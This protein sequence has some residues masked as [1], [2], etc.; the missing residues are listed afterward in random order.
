MS[1]V[2]FVESRD[3]ANTTKNYRW[4][5]EKFFSVV[6][7][8]E[9]RLEDHEAFALRYLEDL[10]AGRR[11]IDTDLDR[12]MK[13]P[14]RLRPGEPAT[15]KDGKPPCLSGWS[16][17]VLKAGVLRWCRQ[18]HFFP[19]QEDLYNLTGKRHRVRT[20]THPETLGV[21]QVAHL[22][23]VFD[24]RMRALLLL[25]VSSGMRIGEA[26]ELEM[27]DIHLDERPCRIVVRYAKNDES[28]TTFCS[29]EAVQ[30]IQD[31]LV[32]RERY[33]AVARAK[34]GG[35][36]ETR[37]FPLS[38]RTAQ[39]MWKLGMEKIGLPDRDPRTGRLTR[40]IHSTRSF[41]NTRMK[42]GGVPDF[43]VEGLLGHAGY[44]DGS[45]GVKKDRMGDEQL[46]EAYLAGEPAITITRAAGMEKMEK[47]L[48]RQEQQVE[49]LMKEMKEILQ[50]VEGGK[51][52]PLLE[53][54]R[55]LQDTKG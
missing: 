10:K 12:V 11:H 50:V 33:L 53:D 43:V 17:N 37:L 25:L 52:P 49:A 7:G 24:V 15:G 54:L 26:L 8:R 28:R 21:D 46:A 32:L 38:Y 23:R 13:T 1:L 35:A 55:A 29:Q 45:Y 27:A 16:R 34:G 39:G 2:E 14:R 31:Y 40:T 3:S 51:V 44:L 22:Q 48:R 19:S 4:A 47:R 36:H 42:M 18:N 6:S 9:G 30:A 20:A 41:F 5:L